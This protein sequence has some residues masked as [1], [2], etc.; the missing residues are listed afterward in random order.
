MF[1]WTNDTTRATALVTQNGVYV[2]SGATTRRY[3]GTIRA[4]A[5]N[6]TEDSATKRFVWNY[7]NRIIKKLFAHEATA[8]WTYSTA[9]YRP[10]NNNTTVGQ[11]RIELL[12]G[13]QEDFTECDA[14]I[15]ATTNSGSNVGLAVGI[16]LDSTSVNSAIFHGSST[17]ATAENLVG[18]YFASIGIGYH[19][20]Q[21]LEWSEAITTTTWYS[22]SSAY[23]PTVWNTG[24]TAK[25]WC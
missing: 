6:A 14:Y 10:T 8:S 17:T 19:Y 7:Y 1:V 22:T 15:I 24:I 5:T 12:I 16:G 13:V 2:K 25:F 23:S 20:L 18:K 11:T 4:S 3:L 21:Q 9:S